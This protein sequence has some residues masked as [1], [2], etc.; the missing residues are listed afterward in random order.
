LGGEPVAKLVV[1]GAIFLV[2]VSL[3]V[4]VVNAMTRPTDLADLPDE[5]VLMQN[6]GT[7]AASS[8]NTA[9]RLGDGT[10]SDLDLLNSLV[11]LPRTAWVTEGPLLIRQGPSTEDAYSA[12]LDAKTGVTVIEFS[13]DGA[14]SHIALPDDGWVSNQFLSF[15]TDGDAKE[16]VQLQVR[17][18]TVTAPLVIHT[19][20]IPDS[21]QVAQLDAGDPL[22]TVAVTLDGRWRQTAEP[23]VGW[24]AASE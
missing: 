14:W 2:G 3:L 7:P 21:A 9:D 4:V 17:R 20:P 22:V 15:L 24:V 12:T 23:V 6:A 1:W 11:T 19:L 18:E 16:L 13:P 5:V 8:A 10:Q